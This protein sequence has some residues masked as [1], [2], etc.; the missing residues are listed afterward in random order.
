M[1]KQL[2][3][4]LRFPEFSDEW[5]IELFSKLSDK[6]SDGIHSTPK[7][8]D[9]GDFHFINGN[10]LVNGQVTIFENTKRISKEESEKHHR[11]LNQNT[12]L[13]SI[14]GTIGNLAFYND[15]RVILGK[16]ACYINL[17]EGL[18]KYFY[19][20]ILQTPKVLNYFNSELTGST[21]KNLS[22][23]TIKKT[24][25]VVPQ[26]E[27]QQKIASFLSSV[28]K[29][30]E[31]L[32]QKKRLLEDY[33]KGTMQQIF[34][35]ELRFKNKEGVEYPKWEEKRLGELLDYEQPTKYIVKSTEYDDSFETPVLTAGKSF[36]L[37]YTDEEENIFSNTPVIIF[38]DFTMSNQFVNF[39][40]KVKS[41]AM[42]IL[43]PIDAEVNIKFVYESMQ[44]INYPKG[45]EHKRFWISE[46][47]RIKIRVPSKEE[48]TQIAN[49]LSAL[50]EKIQLVSSQIEQTQQFK[51]GL[52]QQMFV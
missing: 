3:P 42:K 30:I 49:F 26:I 16:S 39:S 31:L 21:I 11:D 13:L 15:E 1:E 40:F 18:P 29:K 23:S 17:K 8:N 28:D 38:D 43:K 9:K 41:S 14:N 47:S 35:R 32:Q 37:G 10:N 33:K 25:L 2:T 12:V 51:K 36:L 27:E 5:E 46:Y 19:Y 4:V 6:I 20:S 44:M 34:S 50:D 24:K 7:Y 48:Q 22:L 52:L 45:D